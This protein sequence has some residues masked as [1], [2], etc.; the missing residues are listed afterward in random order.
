[1]TQG[2]LIPTDR[3][4]RTHKSAAA[5]LVLVQRIV[6]D[7]VEEHDEVVKVRRKLERIE[8]GLDGWDAGVLQA[9]YTRMMDRLKVLVAELD[10]LGVELVSFESGI[11]C[12]ATCTDKG[13]G[14][15]VWSLT[16]PGPLYLTTLDRAGMHIL[17]GEAE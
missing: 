1:M 7:I 14:V 16:Q 5:A 2:T 10:E 12:F 3:K 15:F 13:D 8:L 17:K 4:L 6:L 11:V 9:E